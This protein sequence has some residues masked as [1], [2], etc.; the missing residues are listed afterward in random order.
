[1]SDQQQQP[2]GLEAVAR[3]IH[4]HLNPRPVAFA[5]AAPEAPGLPEGAVA[6]LHAGKAE[7]HL[8]RLRTMSADQIARFLRWA[9]AVAGGAKAQD[10]ERED[11]PQG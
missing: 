8:E 2:D 10:G 7:G 11:E 6:L 9:A 3:A 5:Q 1:M 4:A